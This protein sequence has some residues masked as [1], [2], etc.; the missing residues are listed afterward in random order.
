MQSGTS[1]PRIGKNFAGVFKTQS[2]AQWLESAFRILTVTLLGLCIVRLGT[3]QNT[4][5]GDIR[6][7]VTDVTG[8]SIPDVTVTLVN[9]DTGV[10]HVLTTNSSGIYDAVSILPG[11]YTI[12]FAKEGFEKVVREGITL[13]VGAISV[14]AQLSVGGTQQQIEVTGE[15]PLLQTETAEQSTTLQARTMEALPNVGQSWENF[16][17]LLPGSSGTPMSNSGAVNPG[18]GLSINGT[19]PFYT[20]FLVDGASIRLPHSANIDDGTQVSE[21]IAETQ[22][23][24]STF[25]AQYGGGGAVFNVITK[26]GANRWHGAL[27]E[28]FENN[29][30]NARSFFDGASAAR[31]RYNNFGGAV[32]GA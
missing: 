30:L 10:T 13:Q 18:V 21:T 2:C 4:N 15:A 17:K 23:N 19:L 25:S 16:L 9:T 5:S 31:V 8:A 20:S 24:T 29:D 28:Y 3:A 1:A 32:G 22:I 11:H 14:D 7:S 27:Y 6:G 12:T 26:S